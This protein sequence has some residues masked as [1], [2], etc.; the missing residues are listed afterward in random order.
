MNPIKSQSLSTSLLI[1][2][3]TSA[4][5]LTTQHYATQLKSA[6]YKIPFVLL[7][8]YSVHTQI[9][10]KKKEKKKKRIRFELYRSLKKRK[11][12]RKKERIPKLIKSMGEQQLLDYILVPFGLLIMAAYHVWLLYRIVKHPTKTVIGVNAINRRFWV[13]AMMEVLFITSFHLL[14]NFVFIV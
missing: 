13:Q 6:F 5:I 2:L 7:S 11:K 12:E 3:L 10:E 1:S 4:C 9:T 8:F 14:I